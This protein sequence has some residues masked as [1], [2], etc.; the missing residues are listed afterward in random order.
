MN[1]IKMLS[2]RK[3]DL[4]KS[5]N[6]LFGNDSVTL[7]YPEIPVKD[8]VKNDRGYSYFFYTIST[9]E[10]KYTIN[11][12]DFERIIKSIESGSKF[13]KIEN[14]ILNVN[15]IKLFKKINAN[16]E[17]VKYEHSEDDRSVRSVPDVDK[18]KEFEKQLKS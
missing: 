7:R 4:N 1:E 17:F 14:D 15:Q 5:A 3:I 13:V 9:S 16:Q 8:F 6:F 11:S 12:E 18:I 2:D 10:V